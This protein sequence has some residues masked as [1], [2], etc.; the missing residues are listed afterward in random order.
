LQK[1]LTGYEYWT[2]RILTEQK[3]GDKSFLIRGRDGGRPAWHYILVPASNCASLKAIKAG[4]NIDVTDH[5]RIIQYINNRGE[6][7]SMSGWGT[8]PNKDIIE[9]MVGHYGKQGTC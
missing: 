7:I 3:L 1:L 5:G 6:T 8:D 4:S 2:K 9:W